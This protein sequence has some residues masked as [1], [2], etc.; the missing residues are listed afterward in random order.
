MRASRTSITRGPLRVASLRSRGS[1]SRRAA[2]QDGHDGPA[3]FVTEMRVLTCSVPRGFGSSPKIARFGRSIDAFEFGPSRLRCGTG[4]SAQ[5]S[6]RD[7]PRGFNEYGE[8]FDL[9]FRC[10]SRGD[11]VQRPMPASVTRDRWRV[12]PGASSSA[13]GRRTATPAG[14]GA[15]PPLPQIRDETARPSRR[16]AG[17]A[18]TLALATAG[19]QSDFPSGG[20][21]HLE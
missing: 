4:E 6:E 20:L 18:I 19:L 14:R 10:K 9:A 15:A 3:P 8:L 1:R 2:G 7:R 12:Q 11:R 21:C 5:S 16:Q 17:R 13:I